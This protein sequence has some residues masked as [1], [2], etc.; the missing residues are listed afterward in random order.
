MGANSEGGGLAPHEESETQ[1]SEV[2]A[3]GRPILDLLDQLRHYE[4][5]PKPEQRSM[6]KTTDRIYLYPGMGKGS[7][8][9]LV[10]MGTIQDLAETGLVLQEGKTV[11]FYDMDGTEKREHDNLL[12]EGTVHYDSE[13]NKWYAIIDW[14]SFRNES[15]EELKG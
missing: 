1:R 8:H 9:Y 7:R 2:A 6:T 10:T 15:D 3:E 14:N 13:L 4:R 12:F 11:S 5:N